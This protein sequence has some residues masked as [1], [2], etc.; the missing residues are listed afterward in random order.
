[1][2]N[3]NFKHIFVL[4]I[5]CCISLLYFSPVLQGKKILQNDIVQY[6]GMA[7]QQNDFAEITGDETYWTNSAF[8]GMPTYQLGA[9]YPHN[10]IKKLDLILRF[11][12]RPADY[13]F[14]YFL[15]FYILMLSLKV[16]Y[17]LA[18]LGA[19]AY[20]F[21]TYLIIII[22]AGHNAKAH[23]IAYMPLVIAGILMVFNGKYSKGFIL[24]TLALGLQFC[25]NHFQM[26]YYLMFIVLLIGFYN[27]IDCWRNNQTRH[28][29][30]S[31]GILFS[32]LFIALLLNATNL[33]ATSEYANESTRGNVSELTI[34]SDGSSKE[35]TTGLDREYITQWSY[36]VFES[37]NLFIPMIMG[38]GSSEDVG[39]DS[40]F[41]KFLRSNG[42]SA[43]ESKQIVKNTPTYWGDQPFVEAP[44]YIGVV[45]FFLFVFS[46]F[47]YNGKHRNWLI[48]AIVLSLLLSYGKNLNFITN[49]FIDYFPLYNK[50]RAVSSIQVI[51]ELCIPVFAILGLSDIISNKSKKSH[52]NKLYKT[53]GVFVVVIGSLFMIKG[54]LSFT[55][56]NDFNLNPS[57]LEVIKQDR[58]D[59]YLN[60]L[61]RASL[62][63]ILIFLVLFSYLKQ[64]TKTPIFILLL[65]VLVIFD[66]APFNKG[67]VNEN[68][69]VDS[70]LV[71]QPYSP[72]R[73]NS[74]ILKDKSYYRVLDLTS[75]STKTSY[76]HNSILGYHAAKL[77]NY[78]EIIEFY[79]ND[80]HMNTLNMLNTKY[81]IF[82][83]EEGTSKL[84]TNDSTNGS[85][86]FVDSIIN[87]KSKDQEIT[88]LDTLDNKYKAVSTE[89]ESKKYVIA[90]S[91][92][93]KLI[94]F[95]PNRMKYEYN[96]N[97][98]GFIVFSE[99]FYPY[100]WNSYINGVK[101][102]HFNV[103]YILRGMSVKSGNNIIEFVFE[104]DVV[105][106]GGMISLSASL[107]F[108]IIFIGMS[109]KFFLKNRI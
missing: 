84:F 19:L 96:N 3:N 21:S 48:S 38:G 77:S 93:V 89:L 47:I 32:A 57:I 79:I 88:S 14:L 37:L 6:A 78:N 16:E 80:V 2:L 73:I 25:S 9:K 29:F 95:S 60:E 69:F 94:E 45:I 68:N 49:L 35:L 51:L 4:V 46:L 17:R 43:L 76:F 74:E 59:I 92:Y 5:F 10:Y 20:G 31:L 18:V 82:S 30:K 106:N 40:N 36:G 64:K 28:F 55:G 44:A 39:I 27:L 8:S 86:W 105:K 104:P 97:N 99:I 70:K 98:N 61:F 34:N 72:D 71:E 91:S 7:K 24:S 90:D 87:V 58:T 109:Y 11:L 1:M 13:L 33:M 66:L 62:F 75:S 67:Y 41:Y 26:T 63:I 53:L 81:I 23:A 50:F 15:G 54:N 12:P 52:L 65:V 83:D 102:K 22:G 103:N 85:A 107:I 101:T 100:G 42:Y 108:L 56:V